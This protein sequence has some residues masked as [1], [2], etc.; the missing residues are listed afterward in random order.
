MVV[1]CYS[2]SQT[3]KQMNIQLPKKLCVNM[4]FSDGYASVQSV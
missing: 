3:S 2:C 1:V 4:L